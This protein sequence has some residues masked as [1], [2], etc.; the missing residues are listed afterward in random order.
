[1]QR[2][3]LSAALG[4]VLSVGVAAADDKKSDDKGHRATITKID[5]KN[6]T[7]MVKMKGKDGKDT[8]KTF[9]LTEEIRYA[10]STGKVVAVDVF[11]SG[12][13][14]LVLEADGKL[15]EVKQAKKDK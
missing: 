5:A 7:L 15:K 1:M 11:K 6:H 8:E 2:M 12:D 14:V 13:E 4:L 10:D 9:K 3:V